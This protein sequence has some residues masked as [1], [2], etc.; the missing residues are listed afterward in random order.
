MN[1]LLLIIVYILLL[2]MSGKR[3]IKYLPTIPMYPDN[4]KEIL[5]VK[6]KN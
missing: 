5:E 3:Y 4:E 1:I 2:I 6:K